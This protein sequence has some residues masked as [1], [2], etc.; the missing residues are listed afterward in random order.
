[1][2]SLLDHTSPY[3]SQKFYWFHLVGDIPFQSIVQFVGQGIPP[4]GIEK[5]KYFTIQHTPTE[6]NQA[7]PKIFPGIQTS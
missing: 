2:L 5:E 7:N 4:L 1:M 3:Q 6:K